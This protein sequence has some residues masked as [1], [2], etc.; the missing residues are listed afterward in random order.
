[1]PDWLTTCRACSTLSG[2]EDLYGIMRA[3][4]FS[5]PRARA[6]SRAQRLESTPPE[7]PSTTREK[8]I[9]VTSS[10]IKPLSIVSARAGLI[11][12]HSKAGV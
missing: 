12:S 4:T 11:F 5:G 3:V 1:M 6:A 8:L 2:D 7:S 9:L 10:R